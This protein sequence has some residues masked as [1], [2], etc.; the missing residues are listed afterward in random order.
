MASAWGKA[1]GLAW[2]N[3]W[4]APHA[5]LPA[6]LGAGIEP[7]RRRKRKPDDDAPLVGPLPHETVSRLRSE[8]LSAS[9]DADDIRRARRRSEE[10]VLLLMI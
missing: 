2:G 8:M 7:G 10:A 4:G 1:W 9:L 6:S 5:I 3:A